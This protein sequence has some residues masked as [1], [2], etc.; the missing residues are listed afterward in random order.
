MGGPLKHA[1]GSPNVGGVVTLTLSYISTHRLH[2]D[3]LNVITKTSIDLTTWVPGQFYWSDPLPTPVTVWGQ[4]YTPSPSRVINFYYVVAVTC[5]VPYSL[6][7]NRPVTLRTGSSWGSME[8]NYQG[9]GNNPVNNHFCHGAVDLTL[10]NY[11]DLGTASLAPTFALSGHVQAEGHIGKLSGIWVLHSTDSIE[12]P[13]TYDRR[14]RHRRH[15]ASALSCAPR[16]WLGVR[17][18][19]L[20]N[21][22]RGDV[23]GR[24]DDEELWVDQA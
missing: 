17:C 4:M 3:N 8:G 2:W 16:P 1:D 23:N 12:R 9:V 19:S 10:A 7:Q 14:S 18:G 13:T 6:Y 5:P 21:F 24:H 20:Q 15:G 22:V 11:A